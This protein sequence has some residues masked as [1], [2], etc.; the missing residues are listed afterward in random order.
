MTFRLLH[1]PEI[2]G[3][4][5]RVRGGPGITPPGEYFENLWLEGGRP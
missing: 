4:A 1:L 3:A 5:T 2:M